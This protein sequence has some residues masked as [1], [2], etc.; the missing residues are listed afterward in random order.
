MP[1]GFLVSVRVGDGQADPAGMLASAAPLLGPHGI[2][3]DRNGRLLFFKA[4]DPA[5]LAVLAEPLTAWWQGHGTAADGGQVVLRFVG[6]HGVNEI[7]Y[8]RPD[9]AVDLVRHTILAEAGPLYGPG[10]AP[11]PVRRAAAGLV[12]RVRTAFTATEVRTVEE[13]GVF[14]VTLAGREL[15]D[16]PRSLEFQAVDPGHDYYDPDDDEGLCLVTERHAPSYGGVVALRLTDRAL[17]LR[18]TPAAAADL[19][20]R[21]T[22]LVVRLRLDQPA[23][24]ELRNG[25]RRAF[26]LAKAV[27]PAPRL[28]LG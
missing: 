7:T 26:A 4:E 19:G 13:N 27:D 28:D 18:L 2:E 10:E 5:A 20:L 1:V 17:R 23:H 6:L 21:A 9:L 25:L 3:V 15:D 11:G 12:R 8:C 22:G 14:C 16:A 24:E